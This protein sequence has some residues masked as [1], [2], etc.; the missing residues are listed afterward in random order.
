MNYN[1]YPNLDRYAQKNRQNEEL[2]SMGMD[3]RPV[4][5]GAPQSIDE[6][7]NEN[8]AQGMLK[9]QATVC[10]TLPVPGVH[11]IVSKRIGEETRVFFEGTTDESGIIDGIVLPAPARASSE[12]PFQ[13]HPLTLYDIHA[14]HP[15]YR[16]ENLHYCAIFDGIKSI[17]PID[18]FP[19]EA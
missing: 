2:E 4:S 16:Q 5:P 15:E 1:P 18:L 17:Q 19:I 3:P 7:L 8:P 6:F 14:E 12:K 10:Q 11:I 9:I 13:P